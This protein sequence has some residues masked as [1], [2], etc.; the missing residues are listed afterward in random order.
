MNGKNHDVE[1]QRDF[2]KKVL[3][4]I[5]SSAFSWEVAPSLSL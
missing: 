2:Q 1:K 3:D 4:N 5:R